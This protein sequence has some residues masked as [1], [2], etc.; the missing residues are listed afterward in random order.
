MTRRESAG[1]SDVPVFGVAPARGA[2]TRRVTAYAIIRNATG[3][4]AVVRTPKGIFLPGGGVE[5]DESP[6]N[7]VHREVREECAL[8]LRL[9]DWRTR[10]IEFVRSPTE[11]KTF[12]KRSTFFD[13]TVTATYPD[14]VELDHELE[15]LTVD[16]AAAMLTPPSHRWA[17]AQWRATLGGEKE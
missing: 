1:W 6:T 3:S 17:I 7:A 4:V 11:R 14:A 12:E 10:A 8:A 15:W 2:A 9:G 16:D 13:A 5:D